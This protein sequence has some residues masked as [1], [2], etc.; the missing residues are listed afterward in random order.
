MKHKLRN[1]PQYRRQVVHPR[2]QTLRGETV[3]MPGTILDIVCK[4]DINGA[5]G[6]SIVQSY[7][8]IGSP[9]TI[10][11]LGR[12]RNSIP[13]TN[14]FISNNIIIR[15]GYYFHSW[16]DFR[17][18]CIPQDGNITRLGDLIKLNEKHVILRHVLL[19]RISPLLA[20]SSPR[21]TTF[22]CEKMLF[23]T[24]K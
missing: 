2:P 1:T 14:H 9:M 17:H 5:N 20:I 22:V 13:Y 15:I 6:N 21:G 11:V 10:T 16:F 7:I 24:E 12:C 19:R 4:S 8:L 23:N 18:H 3:A